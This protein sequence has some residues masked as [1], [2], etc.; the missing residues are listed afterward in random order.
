R[1]AA[2][3]QLGLGDGAADRA[4]DAV[5][6]HMIVD[7]ELDARRHRIRGDLALPVIEDLEASIA[8]PFDELEV[9]T[10]RRPL[11]L[12]APLGDIVPAAVAVAARAREVTVRVVQAQLRADAPPRFDAHRLRRP[13]RALLPCADQRPHADAARR[14]ALVAEAARRHLE[15]VA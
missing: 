15:L 13:P 9:T 11:G 14:R 3:H 12:D 5:T 1:A 10:R 4:L 6:G 8:R 7:V 2:V